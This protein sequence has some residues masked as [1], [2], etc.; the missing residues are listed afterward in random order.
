MRRALTIVFVALLAFELCSGPR[1]GQA[2]EPGPALTTGPQQGLFDVQLANK[3]AKR[4]RRHQDRALNQ[5]PGPP[6]KGKTSNKQKQQKTKP[7]KV[8]ANTG[9]NA[10]LYQDFQHSLDDTLGPMH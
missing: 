10:R 9:G 5:A 1:A 4:S 8:K 2:A 7:Q 3:A 6:K